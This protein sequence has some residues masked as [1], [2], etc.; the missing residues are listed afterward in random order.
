MYTGIATVTMNKSPVNSLNLEF[1]DEIKTELNKL[2]KDKVK[3]MMLT[4]VCIIFL[5]NFENSNTSCN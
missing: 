3:G 5:L 4:S 1:L 2:E